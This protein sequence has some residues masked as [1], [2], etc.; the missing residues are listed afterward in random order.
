MKMG[1]TVHL[2]SLALKLN[3]STAATD[4]VPKIHRCVGY[5]VLD[6]H[7]FD[8]HYS[9]YFQH[10]IGH[11]GISRADRVKSDYDNIKSKSNPTTPNCS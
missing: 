2:N 4:F 1:G 11:E 7:V 10:A 8:L 9:Y 6:Q 3:L 5:V